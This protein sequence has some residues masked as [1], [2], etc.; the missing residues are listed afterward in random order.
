MKGIYCFVTDLKSLSNFVY[1]DKKVCDFFA[2][3]SLSYKMRL[4]CFGN[5]ISAMK[6]NGNEL[7]VQDSA[8][9]FLTEKNM[10]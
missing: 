2:Q 10:L 9:A 6:S 4:N 3:V 1:C 7:I 5:C 8:A